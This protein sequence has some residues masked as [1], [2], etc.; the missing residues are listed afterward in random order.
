MDPSLTASREKITKKRSYLYPC[1][2]GLVDL[3]RKKR[4]HRSV[5][6]RLAEGTD[7]SRDPTGVLPSGNERIGEGQEDGA[8][9]KK[10]QLDSFEV[11]G[12]RDVARHGKRR[13]G[14]GGPWA[15]M[16][17]RVGPAQNTEEFAGNFLGRPNFESSP[18]SPE[19]LSK[20]RR[21]TGKSF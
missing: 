10:Q 21:L 3:R 13:C 9:R 1:R 5:V 19:K 20:N 7:R 12:W 15:D 14:W 6:A 4:R 17:G 18:C 16:L 8:R 11:G 2:T